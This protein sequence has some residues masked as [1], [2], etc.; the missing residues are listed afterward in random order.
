MC[1]FD[2]S[3]DTDRMRR[4][5]CGAGRSLDD[6]NNIVLG[7][8]CRTEDAKTCWNGRGTLAIVA[9]TLDICPALKCRHQNSGAR[10]YDHLLDWING[11]LHCT[12]MLVL[13]LEPRGKCDYSKQGDDKGLACVPCIGQ[14]L[15]LFFEMITTPK[16]YL[17]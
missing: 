2:G 15:L 16:R 7:L 11:A 3:V 10:S 9:G 17:W 12:H 14:V 1:G 5:N 13:L 4:L 6:S 8:L